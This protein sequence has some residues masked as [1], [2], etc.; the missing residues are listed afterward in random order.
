MRDN[1]GHSI[2]ISSRSPLRL[3]LF[4]LQLYI[5]VPNVSIVVRK[6]RDYRPLIGSLMSSYLQL[7]LVANNDF[8][9]HD[10]GWRVLSFLCITIL[11]ADAFGL[12][13]R[14]SSE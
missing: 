2:Y 3:P 5:Y 4:P 10:Y 14:L 7:H 1:V 9:P 8:S 12:A 6:S 13:M 11:D